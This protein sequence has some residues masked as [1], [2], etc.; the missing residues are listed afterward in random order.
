MKTYERLEVDLI[1][2]EDKLKTDKKVNKARIRE[3][4]A[5]MNVHLKKKYK[6]LYRFADYIVIFSILFNIGALMLTNIMVVKT[7]PDKP[8]MEANPV[9]AERL[10]VVQAPEGNFVMTG[11][12]VN[13]MLYVIFILIH[14]YHRRYTCTRHDLTG[15]IIFLTFMGIA[16][17]M[18]F[19]NNLGFAIGKIIFTGGII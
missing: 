19:F 3:V 16:L 2:A 10:D 17:A 14:L 9:N 4:K 11:F 15:Y 6:S 8:L 1:K 7:M 18:D 13:V 12:F 5:R